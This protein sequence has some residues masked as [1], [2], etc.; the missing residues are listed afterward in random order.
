MSHEGLLVR[1]S[2]WKRLGPRAWIGCSRVSGNHGVEGVVDEGVSQVN[3]DSGMAI[4]LNLPWEVGPNK[5]KMAPACAS[6]LGESPP[7]AAPAALA[8]SWVHSVPPHPVPSPA[9][10]CPQCSNCVQRW[11]SEYV[12]VRERAPQVKRPGPQQPSGLSP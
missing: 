5:G 7:T 12:S 2:C 6:L 11:S 1:K 9:A 10:V 8:L 3:G 4:C